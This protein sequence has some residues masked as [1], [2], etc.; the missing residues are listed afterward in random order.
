M[1]RLWFA[2]TVRRCLNLSALF[3]SP[4][5][6]RILAKNADMSLFLNVITA[7]K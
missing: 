4:L 6:N 3:V 1:I 2:P 5:M 7:E